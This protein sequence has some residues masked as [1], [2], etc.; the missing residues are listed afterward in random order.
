MFKPKN[1]L[2]PNGKGKSLSN[3]RRQFL[4]YSGATLT[5]SG[6]FL[7]GCNDDDEMMPPVDDTLAAP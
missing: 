3:L 6:L 7:V 4:A 1:R 2:S 5:A